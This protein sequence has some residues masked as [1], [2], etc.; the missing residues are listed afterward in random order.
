MAKPDEEAHTT[1]L[2]TNDSRLSLR[3]IGAGYGNKQVVFDIDLDVAPS[4]IVVVLGHNGAGKSTTMLTAFGLLPS[5]AG[6]VIFSGQNASTL[7]P[8]QRVKLGMSYVPADNFVFPDLTVTEN[9]ALGGLT[10]NSAAERKANLTRILDTWSILAERKSQLAGTM[11]G[12]QRR[13]LS[14]G[15][16]LMS[17][18]KL[19]LLDEPSLGLAPNIVDQ[20]FADLRSL[21]DNEGLSVLLIEQSVAK[22]LAVAD[23]AYVM[24][25]GRII[26][27]EPANELAGRESLWELF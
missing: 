20:L 6:E 23:D 2:S 8:R 16:A 9:L 14:L 26:A 3:G 17:S 27:H 15:I 7:S 24:Q 4:R 5:K 10:L 25:S 13:M 19:L 12:G 11:S 22:A 1:V 21:A 18:P